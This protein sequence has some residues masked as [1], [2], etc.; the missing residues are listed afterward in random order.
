[1]VVQGGVGSGAVI[2]QLCNAE[3]IILGCST[4]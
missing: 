2:G 1:M 4:N 3:V